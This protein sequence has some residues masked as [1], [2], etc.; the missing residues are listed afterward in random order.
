MVANES[1]VRAARCLQGMKLPNGWTVERLLERSSRGTGGF[2][3]VGYIVRGPD[4]RTAF[5]KAQDLASAFD[6]PDLMRALQALTT[7][8]NFERDLLR[9]CRDRRMS[10][11]VTAIDEGSLQVPGLEP[12]SSHVSYLIFDMADGD[13]R[14]ALD[15]SDAFDLAWRLR[16]LHHVATGLRQMHGHG[17]AHQ[18]LKPSN[19]LVFQRVESRVGDLGRA[20]DR[21]VAGP[22][23]DLPWAG[24]RGYAPPELL[25]GYQVGEWEAR[26]FGCDAY[27][28]GSLVMF[29]FCRVSA[30]AAL[31]SFLDPAHHWVNWGDGFTAVLPFLRAA[32]ERTVDMFGRAVAEAAPGLDGELTEIVREL[33]DPDPRLRGHP[34]TR[35]NIATQFSLERYVSRFDLLARR[36][37]IRR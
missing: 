13:V 28:L 25:Y 19:V 37:E 22:F 32:F 1:R 34:L 20:C 3:S 16:C 2:F 35:S 14:A 36:A 26:R 31:T 15:A 5:L 18:D 21:Q 30:T 6:E 17:I 24:D 33:C 8:F 4:D 7:R 12:P 9:K 10:R 29:F 23:D 11:V 27:L